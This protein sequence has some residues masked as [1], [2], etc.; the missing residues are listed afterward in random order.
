VVRP[1]SSPVP[2]K[3]MNTFRW[4]ER[5]YRAKHLAKAHASASEVLHFYERIVGFQ[6]SLYS[7]IELACGQGK[8]A[9]APGTLRDELDLFILLPNFPKF[10]AFVETMA[11]APLA[12]SA[13]QLSA[14]GAQHWQWLL[15]ASWTDPERQPLPSFVEAALSRL[16]LQPYAEYLA[17]H[18]RQ[19]PATQ[20]QSVCPLCGQKPQAGVLRREGDGGKRSLICSLCSN[21]WDFRRM[22]CPSCGE[23]N[24][25]KLA[26][27]TADQF[28]H[29][30]IEA[31]DSCHHYIK[32][33]DLTKNGNA[34][35]VVDELATVSL[36][37]WAQ[38][39]NYKKAQPNL[40]GV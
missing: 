27:Y 24:A 3:E 29:I 17:D 33:I 37:L 26:I 4:D 38:E 25:E 34:V 1:N 40:F 13:S 10:L 7:D 15:Q 19:T 36:N 16:F 39:H 28:H 5:V 30:R 14:Q 2:G 35:P 22:L 12:Q 11:P 6:K 23:E 21:E 31:C 18:T 8:E 9:R 20:L 32:T